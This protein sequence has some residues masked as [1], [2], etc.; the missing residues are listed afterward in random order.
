[1]NNTNIPSV[2][3]IENVPQMMDI[4]V[5]EYDILNKLLALKKSKS[6]GPD[7]IHPHMLKEEAHAVKVPP[8]IIFNNSLYS[9]LN[10]F[11]RN[12]THAITNQWDKHQ[13]HARF[14]N[15]SF[16]TKWLHM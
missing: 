8:S 14:Q 2:D 15:Q 12:Q 5:T 16:E 1:M 9:S 3:P 4:L 13:W 10:L 11:K 7:G 6:P